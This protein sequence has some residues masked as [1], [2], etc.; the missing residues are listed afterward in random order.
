V[1]PQVTRLLL[2]AAWIPWFLA[3]FVPIGALVLVPV[4]GGAPGGARAGARLSESLLGGLFDPLLLSKVTFTVWQAGLS[5]VGAGVL[6]LLW[7]W[8]LREHPRSWSW[9]RVP[10]G[11]P[12]LAAVAAWTGIFRGTSLAYSFAA[13]LIVHVF[14]NVPWVALSVAQASSSVPRIWDDAA[15]SLGAG[16]FHRVRAVWWPVIGPAWMGA[17]AQVFGFCS[18]SFA[19]VLL[20]GGGP[21]VETLE[22]AIFSSVR[23]GVLDLG[24]AARLAIWQ[25][26]LSLGPWLMVR[27]L[28]GRSPIRA[29]ASIQDS[30]RGA[31]WA[32]LLAVFWV[33]P[34]LWFL[35]DLGSVLNAPGF[36]YG[37]LPALFFS[38]VLALATAALSVLWAGAAVVALTARGPVRAW[39]EALLL[40]PAGLS[41]LTLCM[42]FW[43]AY[44]N[45]IDP[46]DGSVTALL[47]IQTV[48]YFPIVLRSFLPLARVRQEALWHV[49]RSNGAGIWQA[50]VAVEW[51]RWRTPVASAAVLVASASLGDVAAISFFGSSGVTTAS[52]LISRWMGMYQF[53]R[54][55]AL[56]VLLMMIS[57][58]LSLIPWR[59]TRRPGHHSA[60]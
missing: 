25:L 17:M 23:T 38:V 11:V 43:L 10:F 6:G 3:V 35:K 57:L 29:N 36:W 5:A 34:Y 4:L 20:L 16:R 51:P 12:T 30:D 56:T 47:V 31:L 45:W 22:T 8:I 53:D 21:P 39:Q 28:F 37:I 40:I 48:I 50:F 42:G 49:A 7:G 14:F 44:S 52:G 13:V 26:A 24:L 2:W 46:F 1:D 54:A 60:G 32:S 9:L 19:I 59:P 18:A 15:R 27:S 33:L 58:G 55:Y 41:T